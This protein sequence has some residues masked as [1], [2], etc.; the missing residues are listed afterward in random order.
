MLVHGLSPL[1]V[2]GGEDHTSTTDDIEM[3]DKSTKTWK[4]IDSL[5]FARSRVAI[6]A[7]NNND[8]IVIGGYTK[9]G[10]VTNAMSSSLTVVELG[11][12]E[13]M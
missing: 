11:Q 13:K 8:I 6:A 4:K 5:S 1:V 9:V 2:V 7:I 12:V 10:S 3:Y